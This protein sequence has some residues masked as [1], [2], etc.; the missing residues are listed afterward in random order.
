MLRSILALFKCVASNSSTSRSKPSRSEL[1]PAC[2]LRVFF[3]DLKEH[4][5]RDPLPPLGGLR[6][7]YTSKV[8]VCLVVSR[9]LYKSLSYRLS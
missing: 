1:E 2:E 7:Y 8:L 5:D 6:H 9:F 3:L 4:L